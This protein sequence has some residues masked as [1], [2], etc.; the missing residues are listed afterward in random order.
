MSDPISS[1]TA[2]SS[3]GLSRRSWLAVAGLAGLAGAG[4]AWWRFTPAPVAEGVLS[5]HLWPLVLETPQGGSLPLAAF[6]GRK[7]VLNFW[8]TWCPPCVE[9]LPMLNAFFEAHASRGWHVLGLAVDQA[10]A[11]RT[12]L[13]KRPLQFPVGMAGMGGIELS[14]HLGNLNGGLPFTVIIDAQG[15]IVQRKLGKVSDADLAQWAQLS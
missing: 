5:Q 9:E 6:Q 3:A 1:T 8:A 4:T 10:G 11:V 14:K 15:Q 13:Q 7:L 12:F 2:S